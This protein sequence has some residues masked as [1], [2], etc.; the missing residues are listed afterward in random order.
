M[1]IDCRDLACPRPV[2]ETKKALEE[3]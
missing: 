1:K 3:L 2:I